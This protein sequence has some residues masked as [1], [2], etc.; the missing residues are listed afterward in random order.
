MRCAFCA[1][2]LAER[3]VF[4]V[5]SFS[6]VLIPHGHAHVARLALI[7]Y[8]VGLIFNQRSHLY[9]GHFERRRRPPPNNPLC[10]GRARL[11]DRL[12]SIKNASA[13]DTRATPHTHAHTQNDTHHC[14]RIRE[15]RTTRYD[16]FIFALKKRTLQADADVSGTQQSRT[17]KRACASEI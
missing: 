11:V 5:F 7:K 10:H 12:L 16:L 13:L 17:R 8:S 2:L 9:M 3:I 1:R 4:I 15:S 14:S 6:F